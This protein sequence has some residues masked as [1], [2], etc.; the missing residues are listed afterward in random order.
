MECRK[1]RTKVLSLVVCVQTY[2]RRDTRQPEIRHS[3][4]SQNTREILGT[5]KNSKQRHVADRKSG[6]TYANES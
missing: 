5:I 4:Q 2:F 3:D 1:T 6:K